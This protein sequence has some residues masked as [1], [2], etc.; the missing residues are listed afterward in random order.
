METETKHVYV[1]RRVYPRNALEQ[2]F[3]DEKLAMI[4]AIRHNYQLWRKLASSY[5]PD[6][7]GDETCARQCTWLNR[8]LLDRLFVIPCKRD[9]ELEIDEE[10]ISHSDLMSIL[11][12]LLRTLREYATRDN[13]EDYVLDVETVPLNVQEL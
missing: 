4:T 9:A 11:L 12:Y 6:G 13:M 2:A 5:G 8:S 1:T 10:T 7:W 3:M